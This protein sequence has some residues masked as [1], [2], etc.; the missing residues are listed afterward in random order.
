MGKIA[1]LAANP[2]RLLTCSELR[3]IIG[4]PFEPC[5]VCGCAILAV[6][7]DGTRLCEECNPEHGRTVAMRIIGLVGA[8]GRATAADWGLIDEQ[9]RRR[10]AGLGEEVV[11]IGE[12]ND[13]PYPPD[14]WDA[15]IEP[16]VP[17]TVCNSLEV[18]WDA[19]DRRQCQRCRPIR[20][21]IALRAMAKKIMDRKV[22]NMGVCR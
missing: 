9:R 22:V 5:P 20:R 7:Q 14:E 6:L 17:C 16:P 19:W 12:G 10:L 3:A 13:D 11:E 1:N 2:R 15:A 18:W 21:N 4:G 8:D